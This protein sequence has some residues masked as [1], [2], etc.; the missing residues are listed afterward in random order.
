M[1]EVFSKEG[2]F[3]DPTLVKY[4]KMGYMQV[5]RIKNLMWARKRD[6]SEKGK[7]SV[8]LIKFR[9]PLHLMSP[10]PWGGERWDTYHGCIMKRMKK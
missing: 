8:V 3:Y 4:R 7:Y 6:F 2:S 9:E 10:T 5:M 1:K